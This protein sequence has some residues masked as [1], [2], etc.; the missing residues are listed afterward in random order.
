M[1]HGTEISSIP[2][3]SRFVGTPLIEPINRGLS[4]LC[5]ALR[6]VTRAD[7][8]R[9]ISRLPDNSICKEFK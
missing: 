5:F 3:S 2:K 7:F 9:V 8:A 1:E 6:F 4:I